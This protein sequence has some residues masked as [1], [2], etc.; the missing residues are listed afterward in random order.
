MCL[1]S[2]KPAVL[3]GCFN[4]IYTKCK[5]FMCFVV[6]TM[7]TLHFVIESGVILA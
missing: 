7:R 4:L 1:F 2:R 6:I 3:V 5:G